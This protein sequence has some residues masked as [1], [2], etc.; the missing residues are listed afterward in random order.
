MRYQTVCFAANLLVRRKRTV[1][2]IWWDSQEHT[3]TVTLTIHSLKAKSNVSICVKD[4]LSALTFELLFPQNSL[5]IRIKGVKKE[6]LS[7]ERR[8]LIWQSPTF[9]CGSQMRDS[10]GICQVHFLSLC[11]FLKRPG[12]RS[13]PN[14]AQCKIWENSTKQSCFFLAPSRFPNIQTRFINSHGNAGRVI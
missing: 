2:S 9:Q 14:D 8:A 4:R 11:T 13:Q 6:W 1:P 12:I 3:Q 7:K 5:S 10:A